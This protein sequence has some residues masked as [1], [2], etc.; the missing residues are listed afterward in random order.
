MLLSAVVQS[1]TAAVLCLTPQAAFYGVLEKL[2]TPGAT[3]RA[4]H[5]EG[6]LLGC[7]GKT[8]YEAMP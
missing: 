8:A 4:L 6:P 3:E 5:C 1:Q 2:S 7:V